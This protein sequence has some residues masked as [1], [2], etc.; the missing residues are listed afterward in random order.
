MQ[1]PVLTLTL[2]GD[3]ENVRCATTRWS[4]LPVERLLIGRDAKDAR[5]LLNA[6]LVLCRHAQSAASAH[7]LGLSTDF[8]T[9]TPDRD[10]IELEAARETLRRWLIDLPAVFG[11]VWTSE[12]LTQWSRLESRTRIADFCERQVFGLPALTWLTLSKSGIADWAASTPTLPARWLHDLLERAER[13]VSLLPSNVLQSV[14]ENAAAML[15]ARDAGV[16]GTS[17]P[18]WPA[19]ADLWSTRQAEPDLASAL[20]TARLRH[21]AQLCANRAPAPTG[22]M[23]SGD[24]GIGWA[25]CARGLLVHLARVED[26]RITAYRIVP[27]TRWN[28][29]RTG[30]LPDALRG[31]PW[32]AAQPLAQRLMLLLDPCAPYRIEVD[33]H[34]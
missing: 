14:Q 32:R 34:A 2:G 26:G 9:A 4:P 16:A 33:R 22:G 21:L 19:H 28:L 6:T 3:D 29:G 5:A 10:L 15:L 18:V 23:R 7:A 24:I 20:M 12:V 8:S 31:L 1:V 25:R 17:D 13:P 30:L 11:G 27:P